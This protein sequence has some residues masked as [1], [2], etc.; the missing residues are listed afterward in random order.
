MLK[1]LVMLG[2]HRP[3]WLAL[4]VRYGS[5]GVPKTAGSRPLHEGPG[6]QPLTANVSSGQEGRHWLFKPPR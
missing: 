5:P 4:K 1:P 3:P 6:R 2:A